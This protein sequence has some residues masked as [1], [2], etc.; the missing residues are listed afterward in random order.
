[1]TSLWH[2]VSRLWGKQSKKKK[3]K[4]GKD[5]KRCKNEEFLLRKW[6]KLKTEERWVRKKKGIRKWYKKKKK[7]WW[8]EGRKM[9]EKERERKR[10]KEELYYLKNYNE[11]TEEIKWDRKEANMYHGGRIWLRNE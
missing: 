6:W 1:M 3:V 5:K 8:G 11:I 9:I 4:S 2:I 7:N 10:K